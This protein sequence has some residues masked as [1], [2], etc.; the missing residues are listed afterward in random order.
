[1]DGWAP[2]SAVGAYV[3]KLDPAFAPR[4]F[5]HE[6]L[7]GLIKSRPESFRTRTDETKDGAS[8]IHVKAVD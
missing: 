5:G 1:M 3:R 4:S 7:S 2:L 6:S 8:V